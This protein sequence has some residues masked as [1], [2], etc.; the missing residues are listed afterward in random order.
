M[1]NT[2]GLHKRHTSGGTGV[3][4]MNRTTTRA[5]LC[6]LKTLVGISEKACISC[7]MVVRL[8]PCVGVNS[9]LSEY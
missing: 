1:E 5:H 3:P 8:L 4:L 9:N 7:D 6:F 2:D